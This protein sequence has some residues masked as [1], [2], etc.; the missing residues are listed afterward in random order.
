M[1]E[2]EMQN[3][4]DVCAGTQHLLL[5]T[6]AQPLARFSHLIEIGGWVLRV[7][8]RG[9]SDLSKENEALKDEL[10]E[11]KETISERDKRI[12]QLEISHDTV[13]AENTDLRAQ[14]DGPNF[15]DDD[16]SRERSQTLGG[17]DDGDLPEKLRNANIQNRQLRAY[18]KALEQQVEKHRVPQDKAKALAEENQS[19]ERKRNFLQQELATTEESFAK[20][21][22]EVGP[23]VEALFYKRQYQLADH[24]MRKLQE[25]AIQLAAAQEEIGGL[26]AQLRIHELADEDQGLEPI[27]FTHTTL[28]RKAT[29]DVHHPGAP[30]R[31]KMAKDIHLSLDGLDV[32]S[33]CKLFGYITYEALDNGG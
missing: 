4:A 14:V 5:P 2:S 28:K 33:V 31:M 22:K 15:A 1:D 8:Y 13:L 17:L 9:V 18:S 12:E 16:R 7:H 20:L 32:R 24:Q 21:K 23:Y 3:V 25:L 19:L 26:K 29:D 30:K 27:Q 10:K 11:A 6:S